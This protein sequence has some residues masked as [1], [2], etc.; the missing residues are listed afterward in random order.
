MQEEQRAETEASVAD[1]RSVSVAPVGIWTPVLEAGSLR[2]EAAQTK[3]V[4]RLAA[5]AGMSAPEAAATVL[6][7]AIAS[8]K[9]VLFLPQ[10]EETAA[11]VKQCLREEELDHFVFAWVPIRRRPF[12]K[13]RKH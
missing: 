10:Q 7:E 3:G 13:S 2:G 5:P 4:W 12:W 8:G 1:E 11:A 6:S 9:Q